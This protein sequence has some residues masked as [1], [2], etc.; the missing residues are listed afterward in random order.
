MENAIIA[1]VASLYGLTAEQ[2]QGKLKNPE[3]LEALSNEDIKSTL[4]NLHKQKIED[5]KTITAGKSVRDAL[6]SRQRKLAEKYSQYNLNSSGTI[7]EMFDQYSTAI[8]TGNA[9][10]LPAEI[11]TQDIINHAEFQKLKSKF[12]KQ[13]EGFDGL[14]KELETE[15]NGRK[16]DQVMTQVRGKIKEVWL[17]KNPN[18]SQNPQFRE[19]QINTFLSQFEQDNFD[20]TPEGSIKVL[21]QDGQERVDDNYNPISLENIVMSRNF[22]D[23][24][25]ANGNGADAPRYPNSN[26]K[27]S[28]SFTE[29]DLGDGYIAKVAELKKQGNLEAVSELDKAFQIKHF[30]KSEKT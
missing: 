22:F 15:R 10:N 8:Q 16:R 19:R 3:T 5:I 17:S 6:A 1:A 4:H 9:S 7:E 29:N 26:Q 25:Q 11:T 21:G 13:R 24:G 12:D 18:L 27:S 28:F 2:L 23:L 14:K 20:V 30:G